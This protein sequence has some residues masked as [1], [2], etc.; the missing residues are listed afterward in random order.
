MNEDETAEETQAR[1]ARIAARRHAGATIPTERPFYVVY[2]DCPKCGTK[3]GMGGS[4]HPGVEKERSYC[5]ACGHRE[6]GWVMSV[7]DAVTREVA[8]V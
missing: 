8:A 1:L 5:Q 6:D 4:Y 2:P 3:D 7:R